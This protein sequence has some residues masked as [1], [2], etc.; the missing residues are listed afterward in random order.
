[1]DQALNRLSAVDTT[2]GLH[3]IQI[4]PSELRAIRPRRNKPLLPHGRLTRIL[5]SQLRQHD[6]WV[7]T[8]DLAVTVQAHLIENGLAI[9]FAYVMFVVRNRLNGLCR[10]GR[11]ARFLELDEFGYTDGVSLVLW[12]LPGR[13]APSCKLITDEN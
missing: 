13:E 10:M 12:S 7:N 3:E 1:M 11:I 6:D 5:L 2:M 9:D 8:H 4:D